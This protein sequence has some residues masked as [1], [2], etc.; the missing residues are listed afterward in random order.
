MLFVA[1]C[2]DDLVL[3]SNNDELLKSTNK[4]LGDRFDMT[5][6]KKLKYFLGMEV[7]QNATVCR[8]E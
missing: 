5:D 7:D 8:D 4:A 1:L 3:A 2:V 6:M